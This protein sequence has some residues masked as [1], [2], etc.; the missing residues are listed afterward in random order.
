MNDMGEP[1]R[2][3]SGVTTRVVVLYVKQ[4]GGDQAVAALLESAGETRSLDELLDEHGWSSYEQRI[5]L[6]RAAVEVLGDPGA[7]RRIGQS[8]LRSRIA[9]PLV[10]LLRALGSPEQVLRNVAK[11]NSRFSTNS[12]VQALEIGNGHAV[13]TGLPVS[14]QVASA[15]SVVPA[16]AR[17]AHPP[18]R[19]AGRHHPAVPG[20]A[21]FTEE[22]AST[23]GERLI[24]GEPL[25]HIGSWLVA[26]ITSARCRYGKLGAV[27]AQ[28]EPFFAEERQLL[29]AYA[30]QA[31]AALDAATALEEA[32][33]R[34]ATSRALLQLA[35]ALANLAAPE[36]VAE[37]IAAA[38]PD[39]VAA[40]GST[41]NLWD[42]ATQRLSTAATHG[43]PPELEP[44]VEMFSVRPSDT[45]E[46]ADSQPRCYRR[47]STDDP[48]LEGALERFGLSS[49]GRSGQPGGG[50]PVQRAPAGPGTCHLGRAAP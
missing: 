12:T 28:H 35:H 46:L 11:A 44:M 18:P 37:R 50:C 26:D 39:V 17:R 9:L 5:R 43:W 13:V 36:E 3:T 31:A 45:S 15:S 19:P 32:R 2:D 34:H 7:V 40:D 49:P 27:Y 20:V 42:P 30:R 14:A 25:E 23:L 10:V 8:M 47:G 33:R 41:V 48:F 22:E 1:R 29:V 4:H 24:R 21:G 16:R 38:V 6:F